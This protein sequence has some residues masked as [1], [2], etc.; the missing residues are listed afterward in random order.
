VQWIERVLEYVEDQHRPERATEGF[1]DD[2][3]IGLKV[4]DNVNAWTSNHICS[5]VIEFGSR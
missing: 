2:L 1:G 4:R 5:D 3:A